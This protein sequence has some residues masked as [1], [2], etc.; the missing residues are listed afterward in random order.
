MKKALLLIPVLAASLLVG[1]Y[2]TVKMKPVYI[3]TWFENIEDTQ[4]IYGEYQIYPEYNQIERDEDDPLLYRD[5]GNSL[6]KFIKDNLTSVT[7]KKVK[8]YT[9]NKDK[10]F[11]FLLD[12]ETSNGCFVHIY[13]NYVLV[14]YQV[15]NPSHNQYESFLDEYPLEEENGKRIIQEVK[16]RI[17][18]FA[19]E[20]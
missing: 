9:E 15:F 3:D 18:T 11:Y 20:Q 12:H 7:P 16:D 8:K 19:N 4:R 14:S 5:E 13:E 17:A 2:R 6:G 1:C 10:V